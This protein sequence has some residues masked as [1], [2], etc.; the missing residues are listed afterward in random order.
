ML[1]VNITTTSPYH[2]ECNGV[3]EYAWNIGRYFDKGKRTEG[4]QWPNV[5]PMALHA[6]RGMQNHSIGFKYSIGFAPCDLVYGRMIRDP[7]DVLYDGWR[8]DKK[9]V[10]NTLAWVQ[11]LA[12]RLDCIRE[13]AIENK[14]KEV[15]C[16][17]NKKKERW[18]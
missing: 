8:R 7:I 16:R 17:K 3:L 9:G 1:N 2:P 18:E 11:E 6:L 13:I 5:L 12:G 14:R 10:W 15:Q 4:L